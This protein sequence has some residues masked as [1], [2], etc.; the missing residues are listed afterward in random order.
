MSVHQPYAV[1]FEIL[2]RPLRQSCSCEE[3]AEQL[4]P[5]LCRHLGNRR[6]QSLFIA[7]RWTHKGCL[8][9][10]RCSIWRVVWIEQRLQTRS[11]LSICLAFWIL[12]ILCS[13][14]YLQECFWAYQEEQTG[15]LSTGQAA[16]PLLRHRACIVS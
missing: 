3:S 13:C 7:S 10:T 14:S 6:F 8:C 2:T 4:V 5:R 15:Q 11:P 16:L 12:F 9:N 1:P